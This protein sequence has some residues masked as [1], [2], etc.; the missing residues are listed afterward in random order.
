MP[1]LQVEGDG[2]RAS[3][4]PVPVQLLAQRDDLFLQLYR[5]PAGLECGRRERGSK[6]ASPSLW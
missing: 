1:L 5:D 4:V 3:L 2:R 6:A